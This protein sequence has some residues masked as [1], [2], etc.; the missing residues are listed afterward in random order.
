MYEPTQEIILAELRLRGIG[1]V[2]HIMHL[3]GS[4]FASLLPYEL[5]SIR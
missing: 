5:G 4:G 1:S 3:L 2:A